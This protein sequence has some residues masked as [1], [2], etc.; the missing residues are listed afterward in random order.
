MIVMVS[1]TDASRQ[2]APQA[3][4]IAD[5]FHLVQNLR[6]RIEQH[7]SGLRQR[8]VDPIEQR[9]DGADRANFSRADKRRGLQR[10]FAR[11]H[12]LFRQGDH[13]LC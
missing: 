1:M 7:L 5:R 8:P 9:Q 2:G 13:D 4:Q 6:D 11:V 12:E 3:R 10:L